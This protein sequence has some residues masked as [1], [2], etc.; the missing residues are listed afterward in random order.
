MSAPS[1]PAI[2]ARG[3]A[4]AWVGRVA[5]HPQIAEARRI[6]ATD[7]LLPIHGLAGPA[8]LLVPLLV[9]GPPLLVVVGTERLVERVTEDLRTLA[10]ETGTA[11][12]VLALPAPG[13]APF[14]GLPRHPEAALRRAA[15]VHAA[16]RGRLSAL[17]ASPAGLLR[18]VL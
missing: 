9:S 11:G 17:V 5:A 14:R 12:A 8:R 13:P 1:L 4:A 15:A 16:M 2:P 10:Q 7:G 3:L 6:L 18:P